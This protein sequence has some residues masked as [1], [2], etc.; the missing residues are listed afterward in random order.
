VQNNSPP[1]VKDLVLIG[2]GHS[3]VTVL[4]KFGM[5]PVPGVR[6][7]LICKDIMTPYSG[8]LPGL[9]AGHYTFEETH[10]DLGPLARFAGARFYH[11]VATGLDLVD[12]RVICRSRPPV[13]YD[14]VSID[15]GSVPMSTDVPGA[16]QYAVPVKPIDK[17]V[18]HWE[19]LRA[20][21]LARSER[22]RIGVVGGGAG[23][24]E[25]VL[26]IQYRLQ[27]ELSAAGRGV[28]HL[29]YHLFTDTDDILPTHNE[30]VRVKFRRVLNERGVLVRT[31]HR[32]IRVEPESVQCENGVRQELNEILWVTWA[33]AAGWV[34]KTGLDVEE[35][36]FI[37]VNDFLQSTS[38]PSVF[39]AGDVA[40]MI[41]HP[42][43]KAGVFAVRQGPPLS[44][45]LRRALLDQ[46]LKRFKPQTQFLSLVST[47]NQ[48]AVASRS[49]WALE[50]SSV[51]RWKNWI[52]Q[53]FMN[54]YR[55]LP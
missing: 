14:V 7:T 21:V 17:F 29:E 38:H 33:G 32:V 55:D 20:R 22:T 47:G 30:A 10:I 39:A 54:K 44:E 43:P 37:R 11:D 18:A 3:H 2:G 5:K 15:T 31:G 50:G 4:K 19:K 27:T 25:V 23:G 53:R 52:D 13:V 28:D 9:I 6:L 49:G 51:W 1:I 45:N 16:E 42:R 36:G 12:R 8:M 48:Y 26:A 24:V 35:R 46:P 40:S 41:N 34:A